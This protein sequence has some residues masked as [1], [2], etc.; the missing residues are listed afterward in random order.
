MNYPVAPFRI[1]FR[2]LLTLSVA[3]LGLVA[4][5]PAAPAYA[6]ESRVFGDVTLE[7]GEDEVFTA[8]GDVTVN[9]TVPGDVH[10][11]F[12]DVYVN[13]RVGGSVNAGFGDIKVDAPVDGEVDAGFGDVRVYSSVNGGVE[14]E[15]G[16]VYLGPRAHV[17]GDLEL[18]SGEFEGKDEAVAGS[19]MTGRMDFEGPSGRDILGFVGWIFASAVFVACSVL[20]A[21]LAPRPLSAAARRAEEAPGRSFL[22]G[23]ASVPAAI[24]LSVVL[25]V[26]V[27][28]APLLL[29]LAPA[30]L[31][32]VFFGTLVAAFYVGSRVVLA[33]GR[34]RSGNA[35]AA[36]VGALVLAALTL[37]PL[38]GDLLLYALALMGTGGAILA[39]FSRRRP[40]A[41]Y[42]SYE[43]YVRDRAGG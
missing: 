1:S 11:A 14:V 30:Y 16:D 12:G 10:S 13:E 7:G 25:V 2:P 31:A 35:L 17:A 26:S 41:T 34:Y 28:G 5:L 18:G 20:A 33:T 21:V 42:P 8:F 38:V 4:I 24:V 40:L 6:F 3:V 39:L 22:L 23:L 29:L 32:L 36:V 15:H 27:V 43:A 37:I 9:G 19:I